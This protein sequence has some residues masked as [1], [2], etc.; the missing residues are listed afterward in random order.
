[1]L[2]ILFL[3]IDQKLNKISKFFTVESDVS[4]TKS[5]LLLPSICSTECERS[6]L[7]SIDWCGE[8]LFG[9]LSSHHMCCK[10][11]LSSF[12]YN[13]NEKINFKINEN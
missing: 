5:L 4:I 8:R 12:N 9:H 13:S 11:F 6:Q 7:W 3:N 1:M 2:Y 10:Q